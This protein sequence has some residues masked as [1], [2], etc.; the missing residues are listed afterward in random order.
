MYLTGL[1]LLIAGSLGVAYARTVSE[2]MVWRFLQAFGASP[3]IAVGAG[4]IGDI[5]ILE[6]RGTAIGV[7]FS[8]RPLLYMGAHQP[9]TLRGVPLCPFSYACCALFLF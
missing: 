3:G 8:V 6:E 5:Y 9:I 7:F 4:V 2:L 1:P